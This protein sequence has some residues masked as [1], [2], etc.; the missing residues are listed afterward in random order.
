[1]KVPA[2]PQLSLA[3][4]RFLRGSRCHSHYNLGTVETYASQ[5][6]FGWH[7]WAGLHLF[8]RSTRAQQLL[9]NHVRF[10]S[11]DSSVLWLES[12]LVRSGLHC[13]RFWVASVFISPKSGTCET[14]RKPEDSTPL[15]LRSQPASSSYFSKSS[16]VHFITLG[17]LVVLSSRNR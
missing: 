16:Y 2:A 9:S 15:V 12:R 13:W 8:L 17:F 3:Q 14:K 10:A 6:S 7:G 4:G 11:Y 5:L 1:M